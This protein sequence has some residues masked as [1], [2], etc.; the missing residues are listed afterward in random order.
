MYC[1][2]QVALNGISVTP[3]TEVLI[4]LQP[5][6]YTITDIAKV[7]TIFILVEIIFFLIYTLFPFNFSLDSATKTGNVSTQASSPFP[8]TFRYNK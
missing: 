6:L 8:H 7:C 2:L 5:E 4:K 1:I 3:G